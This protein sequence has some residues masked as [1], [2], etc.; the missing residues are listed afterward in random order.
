MALYLVEKEDASGRNDIEGVKAIVLE[1]DDE[2]TA[3]ELAAARVEGDSAWSA[4]TVT[5]I[6]AGV[7]AD[8]EG[9][10][11]R[12]KIGPDPTGSEYKNIIDLSETVA[13]GVEG[14]Q[15]AVIV[16]G[17]TGYDVGDILE[18]QGGTSTA[19]ARLEVTSETGNVIDGIKV[20]D[21]GQYSETPADPVAVTGGNGNDDATFNITWEES[22]PVVAGGALVE[23]LNAELAI[24]G[25]KFEPATLLL[26][27]A[28]GSGVDDL[29]D[30]TL[31]LEV[32]SPDAVR[33]LTVLVGTITDKGLATDD[34]SV[35]L[36]VPTAVPA[37]MRAL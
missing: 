19:P 34:L 35:E 13:A 11:Y 27:A 7:A 18:V 26:T 36:V 4:A 32:T 24:A 20:I 28:A 29:G 37:I 25:A 23:A 22:T 1:A 10:T 12:L 31:V 8:F 15:A 16:A 3:K 30:H 33:P 17:G 5:E 9:F 21:P 2:A 6:A 14:A